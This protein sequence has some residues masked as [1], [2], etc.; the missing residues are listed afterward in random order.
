MRAGHPPT[1]VPLP[2]IVVGG[3]RIAD[4]PTHEP[5]PKV[6][7]KPPGV[8]PPPLPALQVA[9]KRSR[10]RWPR[11]RPATQRGPPSDHARTLDEDQREE[12][13]E[14]GA[15]GG[16]LVAAVFAGLEGVCS[17]VCG[18]GRSVMD[19]S[20]QIKM[21]IKGHSLLACLGK[22]GAIGLLQ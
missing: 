14:G 4:P 8:G 17:H 13:R 9:A 7:K 2:C 19:L 11:S 1:R 6:A 16:N 3:G 12:T 22:R 15:R 20:G 5:P 10:Q 18:G 21:I